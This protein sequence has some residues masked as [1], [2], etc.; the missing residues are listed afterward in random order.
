MITRSDKPGF[1]I[2]VGD[3]NFVTGSSLCKKDT[4]SAFVVYLLLRS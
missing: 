4:P 1:I 2:D 3:N